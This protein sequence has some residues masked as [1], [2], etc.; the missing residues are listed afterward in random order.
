M[1]LLSLLARVLCLG[2]FFWE[3]GT[4]RGIWQVRESTRASGVQGKGGALECV[5]M[6]ESRRLPGGGGL[7]VT[8]ARV[9]G[10]SSDRGRWSPGWPAGRWSGPRGGTLLTCHNDQGPGPPDLVIHDGLAGVVTGVGQLQVVHADGQV[11]L[12][13]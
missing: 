13:P 8:Q 3:E 9:E 4:E 5:C 10:G 12:Q 1:Y 6:W 2:Q 11:V 7:V